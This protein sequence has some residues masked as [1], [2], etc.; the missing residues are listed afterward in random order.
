LGYWINRYTKLS[1]H[2]AAMAG[3]ATVLLW[4]APLIGIVLAL[5]APLVGW[6]RI[7][8]KH[9]TVLQILIGWMVAIVC[10]MAVFAVML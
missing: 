5:L 3:C 1:I 4:T 9:H 2:S 6:A 8:L 7:H 10:V